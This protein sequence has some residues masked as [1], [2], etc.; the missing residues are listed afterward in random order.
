MLNH[1]IC[2]G[3]L[4]RDPELRYT[5]QR[6]PVGSCRVAVNRP[7]SDK[8]DFFDIVA[9]RHNGEFLSKYFAKGQQIVVEGRLQVNEW[10]GDGGQRR[11]SVEIVAEN[12]Y[13]A[14][15]KLGARNGE[16]A[17]PDVAAQNGFR[18]LPDYED[19]GELPY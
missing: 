6:V 13:F 7:G 8:A 5:A 14:G 2:M 4:V 11:S 16:A 18:A 17:E 1:F 12:L 15:G 19:D 3:R 9:W 10:T